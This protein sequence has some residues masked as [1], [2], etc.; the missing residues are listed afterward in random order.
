MLEDDT[1]TSA[2]PCKHLNGLPPAHSSTM[3][4]SL[5]WGSAGPDKGGSSYLQRS[6][7]MRKPVPVGTGKIN[8]E[9][10]SENVGFRGGRT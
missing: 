10:D 2:R 6:F 1:E 3:L 8:A 5:S 4:G 9:P 7:R